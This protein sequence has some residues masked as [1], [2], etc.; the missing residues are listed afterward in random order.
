MTPESV[1]TVP[2][3]ATSVGAFSSGLIFENSSMWRNSEIGRWSNGTSA[4]SI[5]TATRRT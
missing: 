1:S 3:S 5:A 4:V 2:S